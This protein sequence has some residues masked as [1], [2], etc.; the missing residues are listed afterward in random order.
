[1]WGGTDESERWTVETLH[2]FLDPVFASGTGWQRNVVQRHVYVGSHG[3][4]G[5]FEEISERIE[6]VPMRTTG[7]VRHT[8]GQWKIVQYNTSFA[9]P[10]EIVA[11]V[12]D[13]IREAKG[14]GDDDQPGNDNDD[15]LSDEQHQQVRESFDYVWQKVRDSYWDENLGGVD[16]E[17]ARDEL[18]PRLEA[19]ETMAEARRVL[20][21][22]VSRMKVS[23]FSIIPSEAYRELGTADEP[24]NRRGETGI[25]VRIVG[26]DVVVVA[27]RPDTPGAEAGIRPGW[28]LTRIN[29]IDIPARLATVREELAD[30]PHARVILASAANSRLRGPVGESVTC[31]FQDENDQTVE[32]T[33]NL[34]TPRGKAVQFGHLPEFSVWVEQRTLDNGIGYFRFNAF[35]HPPLVMGQFNQFMTDHMDAPGIIID[36]RANGG[37]MGEIAVGM[38]GWLMQG[39]RQSLGKIVLRNQELKMIARPRATTYDG[40]V[41]VLIDEMSVSAAEFFAQGIKQATNARLI[42]TRTAGAVLGSQIEKL[43]NG[44]GFQFAA[45]NFITADTGE[46]LEGIGVPPHE[47]VAPDRQ[48]LLAGKDPAIEAAVQWIKNQQTSPTDDGDTK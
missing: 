2:E 17:A 43:P 37:G 20:D 24:V 40:A 45:A 38:I 14:A 29:E 22:L 15:A 44:D 18:Q 4:I 34:I 8:D 48:S 21:E 31:S 5:W 47:T 11:D 32:H 46:T 25:D 7:V 1:M 23:H 6:G 35:M 13:L 36:V 3:Q 26:N 28:I 27:V 42:G 41:V 10:N 16:W 33:L 12:A 19:A 30:N 9:I 39:E